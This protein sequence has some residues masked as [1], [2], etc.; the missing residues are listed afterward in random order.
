M[1][2]GGE[3]VFSSYKIPILEI[4]KFPYWGLGEEEEDIFPAHFHIEDLT[5]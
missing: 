1:R 5:L 2:G 4:G 3:R